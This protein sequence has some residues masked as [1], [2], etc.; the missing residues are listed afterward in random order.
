MDKAAAKC[1]LVE[2]QR[3]LVFIPTGANEMLMKPLT[4]LLSVLV[5]VSAYH[6]KAFAQAEAGSDTEI[7]VAAER[8]WAKAPV[9]HDV[10]AFAK[11]M[12][13]DYVLIDVNPG[14]DK[15]PRLEVTSKASWVEM[16]RSGR[17]K[18]DA[19]EVHGLKVH[20]NGDIATV[21]GEYSQ[22]GVSDGKDISGA[23]V[24]V[25][26]WIKRNGQWKLVSSVFP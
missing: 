14:P 10:E 5:A 22:K 18:Y 23:G 1:K 25:D 9:D 7:I 12:S 15:K 8:A 21:T 17:E 26:T 11:Y 6:L 16:V 19:V 24:Y 13:D 3:R 2:I 4:I 20:F